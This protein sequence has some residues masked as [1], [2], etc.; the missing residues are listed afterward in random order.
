VQGIVVDANGNAVKNAKVVLT[1][2]MGGRLTETTGPD[3]AYLFHT[4]PVGTYTLVVEADGYRLSDLVLVFVIQD[5]INM[6]EQIVLVPEQ[7]SSAPVYLPVVTHNPIGPVDNTRQLF[8]PA[9]RVR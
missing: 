7:D 2:Q 5:K 8:L 3:G 9:A 6:V 4:V 1:D